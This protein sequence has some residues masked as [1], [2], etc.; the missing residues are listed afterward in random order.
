MHDL[1]QWPINLFSGLQK[2][3]THFGTLAV[4]KLSEADFAICSNIDD[5]IDSHPF[6]ESHESLWKQ[7]FFFLKFSMGVICTSMLQRHASLS[8]GKTKLHCHQVQSLAI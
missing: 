5:I 7:D 8:Y 3:G 2:E 1:G 4:Y 6:S